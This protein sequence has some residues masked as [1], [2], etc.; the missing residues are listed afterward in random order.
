[1]GD[2]A[3]VDGAKEEKGWVTGMVWVVGTAAWAV[4]DTAAAMEVWVVMAV[5]GKEATVMVAMEEDMGKVAAITGVAPTG[6]APTAEA[7]MAKAVLATGVAAVATE[8]AVAV[9]ATGVAMAILQVHG[10][11]TLVLVGKHM[12]C[13]ALRGTL[14]HHRQLQEG[15]LR[16]SPCRL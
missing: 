10:V 15:L 12:E 3:V 11:P 13:R 7:A 6:V 8:V 5:V 1:M 16:V 9:V 2:T 4:V 14:A